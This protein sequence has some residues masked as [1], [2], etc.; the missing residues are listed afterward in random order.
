MYG[1]QEN[2]CPYNEIQQGPK[3]QWIFQNVKHEAE[4]IYDRIFI[5]ACT[6]PLAEEL[7]SFTFQLLL[8]IIQL[9]ST[10]SPFCGQHTARKIKSLYLDL[11]VVSCSACWQKRWRWFSLEF[12]LNSFLRHFPISSCSLLYNFFG[13]WLQVSVFPCVDV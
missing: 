5:F 10:F 1:T 6:I 3:Q 11:S 13:V 8:S 2:F 4:Y 9:L 12:E 7:L